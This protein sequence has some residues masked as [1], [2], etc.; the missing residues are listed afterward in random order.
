MQVHCF[1]LTTNA[2]KDD[3]YRKISVALKYI[4]IKIYKNVI[5]KKD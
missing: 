3:E 5:N 1:C 2:Q 4:V